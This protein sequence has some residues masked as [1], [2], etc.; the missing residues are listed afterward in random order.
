MLPRAPG[1]QG[2]WRRPLRHGTNQGQKPSQLG[3]PCKPLLLAAAAAAAAAACRRRCV[4]AWLGI[5]VAQEHVGLHLGAIV[6]LQ[7]EADRRV[8]QGVGLARQ[9]RWQLECG[10]Q[11]SIGRTTGGNGAGHLATCPST[12]LAQAEG[13]QALS[14]RVLLCVSVRAALLCPPCLL[15]GSEPDTV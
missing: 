1:L 11:C 14:S 5:G 10:G 3:S 15:V 7:Q 8:L 4:A 9:T 13:L 6:Q 12:A 2:L